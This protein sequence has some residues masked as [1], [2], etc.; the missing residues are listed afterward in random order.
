MEKKL[1]TR[2]F[3]HLPLRPS[4]IFCSVWFWYFCVFQRPLS[5][6]LRPGQLHCV[7]HLRVPWGVWTCCRNFR[8]VSKDKKFKLN[9]Y[10]YLCAPSPPPTGLKHLCCSYP[11]WSD[12][13]WSRRRLYHVENCGTGLLSR[14]HQ[15]RHHLKAVSSRYSNQIWF[16]NVKCNSLFRFNQHQMCFSLQVWWQLWCFFHFC[17]RGWV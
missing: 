1:S 4:L 11:C 5:C 9:T 13:E 16:I 14:L 10:K 12:S 6:R 2:S 8:T 15:E 7:R 3:C 17:R